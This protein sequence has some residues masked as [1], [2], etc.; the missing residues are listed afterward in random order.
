MVNALVG[1]RIAGFAR[2]E[3]MSWVW[4]RRWRSR[5]C[6]IASTLMLLVK[7]S[8]SGTQAQSAKDHDCLGSLESGLTTMADKM[9]SPRQHRAENDNYR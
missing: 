9:T 5:V 2:L 8:Q 7:M 6:V 1:G 4:Q 3:V